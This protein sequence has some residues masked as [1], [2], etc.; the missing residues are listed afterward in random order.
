MVGELHAEGEAFLGVGARGG[1]PFVPAEEAA[2]GGLGAAVRV[3]QALLDAQPVDRPLVDP[4]VVEVRLGGLDGLEQ[5]LGGGLA[6]PAFV[7]AGLRRHAGDAAVLVPVE[8]RLDGPPGELSRVAVLA[9][10]GH[11]GDG[12]EAFVAGASGDRIDGPEDPHLQV[13]RRLPH[14]DSPCARTVPGEVRLKPTRR[15]AATTGC[16]AADFRGLRAGRRRRGA[17]GIR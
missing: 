15:S 7:A 14:V 13:D 12:V 17:L 10:E 6:D 2:E 11:G 4:P 1:E 9:R 5:F 16:A 3:E 8:P